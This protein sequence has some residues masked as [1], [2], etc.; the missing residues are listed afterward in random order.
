MSRIYTHFPGGVVTVGWDRTLHTSGW[1]GDVLL[2][3]DETPSIEVPEDYPFTLL[4][5][6]AA[7]VRALG[8]YGQLIPGE[9]VAAAIAFPD[10]NTTM[11]FTSETTPDTP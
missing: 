1:W 9:A 2:D 5:D 4:P 11:H 8:P 3:S 7:V 6:I 10:R